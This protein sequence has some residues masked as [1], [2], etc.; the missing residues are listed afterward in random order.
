MLKLFKTACSI[1]ALTTLCA[2]SVSAHSLWINIHG[3]FAHSPGHVIT[4]L[5]W[6]HAMPLDDFL[7]GQAGIVDIEKYSLMGPDNSI[8]LIPLPV[9]KQEKATPSKTG[10]TLVPGD[11][12]LRK[13]S[14]TDKAMPGTYQVAAESRAT[15]FTGY[16]DAKGKNRM[17]TK[18]MDEI[19]GAQSVNFSTRYKAMAKSY[20]SI[21]KWTPPSPLGYDLE[22]MPET[23]MTNVKAGDLVKF[24]VTLNGKPVT[25]DMKGMNYLHMTSNT[26]GGPDKYM[27]AAYIMNGKAQIRV[28]T[29]GAWRVWVTLEK[30]VTKD[31]ELKH[32]AGKC[33]SIN[34]A[35]SVSFT[36]KP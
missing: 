30:E 31:N 4:S 3:S 20:F 23:D 26:F 18:S 13:I 7:V 25:C 28:P 1:L 22:I 33:R 14:L 35:A 34:Y 12:G 32:L 11:L 6:G 15:Y 2:S 27:L 29:P 24:T 17:A 19:K 8:T 9:I 16:V 5:G 10:M 21:E 36:A